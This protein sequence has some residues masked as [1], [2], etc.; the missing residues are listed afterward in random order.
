MLGKL[1][2]ASDGKIPFLQIALGIIIGVV[3]FFVYA[4]YYR[5]VILFND[6]KPNSLSSTDSQAKVT[7]KRETIKEPSPTS[8]PDVIV[9]APSFPP[10]NMFGL[11]QQ[12]NNA[13]ESSS[14]SSSSSSEE[15]ESEDEL[16]TPAL[17]LGQK[18]PGTVKGSS[19]PRTQQIPP[20][21]IRSFATMTIPVQKN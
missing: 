1:L 10:M 2:Y 18:T 16:E 8:S 6:S 7:T 21:I 9:S 11:G 3:G 5:P 12:D 19:D 4:K 15:D 13:G 14:E 20:Q 17:Q